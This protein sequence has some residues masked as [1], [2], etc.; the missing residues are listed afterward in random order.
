MPSVCPGALAHLS[1]ISLRREKAARP[2][3]LRKIMGWVTPDGAH[4]GGLVRLEDADEEQVE[5][6][7]TNTLV[8]L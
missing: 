1:I 6:P 5:T 2:W 4:V 3:I 7:L 8:E